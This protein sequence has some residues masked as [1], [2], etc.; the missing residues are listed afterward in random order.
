MIGIPF[1]RPLYR[2]L[3]LIRIRSFCPDCLNKGGQWIGGRFNK[4]WE[5]CETC[6]GGRL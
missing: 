5:K 4:Y 6:E 3:W 1:L 2:L